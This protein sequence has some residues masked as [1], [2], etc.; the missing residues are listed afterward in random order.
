MSQCE[1]LMH[2]WECYAKHRK[3]FLLSCHLLL[4]TWPWFVIFQCSKAVGGLGFVLQHEPVDV[5]LFDFTS[6]LV[7]KI[8]SL[9]ATR[10]CPFHWPESRNH[11]VETNGND[12]RMGQNSRPLHPKM[13]IMSR[14]F[15][16]QASGLGVP[17]VWTCLT[18][19]DQFIYIYIIPLCTMTGCNNLS[20]ATLRQTDVAMGNI[21]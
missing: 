7:L 13:V 14:I 3:R 4:V 16:Y 12:M 5:W 17:N 8:G 2:P 10:E 21:F 19:F 11:E 15:Q 18:M 1:E 6:W 20:M 9:L